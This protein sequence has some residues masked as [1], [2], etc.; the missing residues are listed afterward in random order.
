MCCRD[1]VEDLLE[2]PVAGELDAG[3]GCQFFEHSNVSF[4]FSMT[5]I[6]FSRIWIPVD[7]QV[8]QL[9]FVLRCTESTFRVCLQDFGLAIVL[10][11]A[12]SE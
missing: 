8:V 2:V 12:L 9:V 3:L 10:P 1:V 5:P 4:Y 6:C 11:P 7:A